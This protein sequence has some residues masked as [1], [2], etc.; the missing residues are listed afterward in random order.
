MPSLKT[1]DDLWIE[2]IRPDIASYWRLSNSI[3]LLVCMLLLCY[4]IYKVRYLIVVV[5][6]LTKTEAKV[7]KPTLPDLPSMGNEFHNLEDVG[8]TNFNPLHYTQHIF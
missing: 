1:E 6:V 5:S 7:V 4:F 8:T 3:L 2:S